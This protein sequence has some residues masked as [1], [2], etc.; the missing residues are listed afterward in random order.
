MRIRLSGQGEVGPGGGPAGDLYVEIHEQPHDIFTRE[1]DDLH[2]RVQ[3]PMTAAALGTDAHAD[4]PRRRRGDRRQARHPAGHGDHAA[5]PRRAAP[6]RRRPRRPARARRGRRRRPGSTTSRRSCCAS[7]PTLRGEETTPVATR[8][9]GTAAACSRRCGTRSTV[10][11]TPPPVF[12]VDAL[13][14]GRPWRCADGPEGASRR[15]PSG[16]LPRRARARAR[17]RRRRGWPDVR[18]SPASARDRWTLRVAVPATGRRAA[19]P[20]PRLVVVQALAKGDR[21][22][23]AVELMAELGVDEIVPWAAARSV[24]RWQGGAGSRRW[25]GG[26]RRRGRRPSSPGGR[27]CRPSP[28]RRR[29]PRSW[30]ARRRR[31]GAACC[32]RRPTTPLARRRLPDAASSCWSSG[33]RAGSTRRSWPRSPPPGA[34]RFG[35]V[36]D[37]AAHL[38]RRA[39]GRWR[40]CR[41]GR[42]ALDLTLRSE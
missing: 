17:R 25:N 42:L 33:P 19:P 34:T 31:R 8:A 2:C 11:L 18:R 21:G 27:G 40:R 23:L 7:S 12:L 26:G 13:P 1:G 32:T 36:H 5:R 16:R 15:R 20:A 37:G 28:T 30:P 3:L 24:A 10:E 35:S 4:H 41:A 6:A 38:D 9:D 22:E 39:R 29:P 14:D